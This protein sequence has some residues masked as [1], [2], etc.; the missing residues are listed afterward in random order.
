ARS[1]PRRAARAASIAA[2][3]REAR[4]RRRRLFGG[5][6]RREQVRRQI[7][8]IRLEGIQGADELNGTLPAIEEGA[9]GRRQRVPAEDV[10]DERVAS[11]DR[12]FDAIAERLRGPSPILV[13]I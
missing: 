13:L 8:L 3:C 12:A 6:R 5:A 10:R 11:Q 7:A 2:S 9:Y 1:T 4:P